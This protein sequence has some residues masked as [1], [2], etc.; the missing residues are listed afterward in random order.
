MLKH[1]ST[2]QCRRSLASEESGGSR[3]SAV[4]LHSPSA[5]SVSSDCSGS[6]R[7]SSAL[8]SLGEYQIQMGMLKVFCSILRPDVEYKT[9]QVSTDS[10]TKDIVHMLLRKC[11]MRNRDPNLFYLSMEISMLNQ[12]GETMRTVLVLDAFARPLDLKICQPSGYSVN[13]T[14]R[15]KKGSLLKVH[16]SCLNSA[17]KYKSLLISQKTTAREIIQLLL[18]CHDSTESPEHFELYE[19]C[20]FLPSYEHHIAPTDMPLL[21]RSQ[22][23]WPDENFSLIHLRR[24]RV[25]SSAS[26]IVDSKSVLPSFVFG[27]SHE[28][29]MLW[30]RQQLR[31][32][33]PKLQQLTTDCKARACSSGQLPAFLFGQRTDSHYQNY[34][35]V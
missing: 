15:A 24:R 16:D 6:S 8:S 19:T 30:S 11:K 23:H 7:C 35:H 26:L 34:F 20:P 13:F 33:M 17:S 21:M 2:P 18:N 10:T 14:L 4:G 27:Q 12:L 31:T 28:D 3:T 22:Q 9:L 32:F 29:C 5:G 1:V 25:S